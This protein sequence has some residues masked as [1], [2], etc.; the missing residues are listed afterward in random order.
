LPTVREISRRLREA[1]LIRQ[2]KGGRYGAVQIMTPDDAASLLTA[3]MLVKASAASFSA[4]ARVGAASD[5][6][7]SMEVVPIVSEAH[8][9]LA[10]RRE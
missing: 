3:L 10:I 9:S 8:N 1:R 7:P 2:G 4:V 5:C 6:Y